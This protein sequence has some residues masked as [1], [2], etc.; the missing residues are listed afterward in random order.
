MGVGG[1]KLGGRIDE[2]FTAY[3]LLCCNMADVHDKKTR[4]RNMAAIKGNN[5][6]LEWSFRKLCINTLSDT[7]KN[8]LGS[9]KI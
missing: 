3:N 8:K 9:F 7:K 5:T 2:R 1:G 4:S 6:K